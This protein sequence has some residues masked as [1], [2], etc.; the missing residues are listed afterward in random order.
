M[1]NFCVS[2]TLFQHA[3]GVVLGTIWV[4]L[5]SPTVVIWL[6]FSVYFWCT[7]TKHEFIVFCRTSH[8]ICS[9]LLIWRAWKS[10]KNQL[11]II[12]KCMMKL[13]STKDSKISPKCFPKLQPQ[14]IS[15]R[16]SKTISELNMTPKWSKNPPT[17]PPKCIQNDLRIPLTIW[18]SWHC[19]CAIMMMSW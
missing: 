14:Q 8:A 2:S 1:R 18:S 7:G 15:Q 19:N 11:T 13:T 16:A 10:M 5:G 12:S 4:H 3:F 6:T 9:L 17:R